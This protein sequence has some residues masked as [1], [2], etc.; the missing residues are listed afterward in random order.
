MVKLQK[1]DGKWYTIIDPCF[2][3]KAKGKTLSNAEKNFEKAWEKFI[4]NNSTIFA[5]NTEG[6]IEH[7]KKK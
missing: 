3:V 4:T 5:G 6:I 1:F 7:K 2:G